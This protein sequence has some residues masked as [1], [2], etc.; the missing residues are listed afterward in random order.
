[1]ANILDLKKLKKEIRYRGLSAADARAAESAHQKSEASVSE[2][3]AR[4]L[5]IDEAEEKYVYE[6]EAEAARESIPA[7]PEAAEKTESREAY[8]AWD[9]PEYERLAKGQLWFFALGFITLAVAGVTAYYGNYFFTLFI[10]IAGALVG[11][12]GVREPKKVHFAVTKEGIRLENR[13][14]LFDELKS[15]WIFYEPPLFK[16]LSIESRKAFMPYLKA[17]LG[18][19]D[20][21]AIREVLAKFL[22][23][24]KQKE[25]F[26]TI[27][28][29]LAR[30]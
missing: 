28:S 4:P 7:V 22:P 21:D 13:I 8:I 12:F 19:A 1:M 20:P 9:A 16:E 23:E 5:G 24:E 14:Y 27:L 25:S 11:W 17:P 15:F 6:T 10:L 29:H 3:L 18:D 2:S 30:F 26:I